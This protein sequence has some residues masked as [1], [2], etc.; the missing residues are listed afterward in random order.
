LTTLR[1]LTDAKDRS[2]EMNDYLE[3]ILVRLTHHLKRPLISVQGALSNVR[4]IRDKL[5]RAELER[6]IRIGILAAK[7]AVIL[8][9][10]VS[11]VL[12]PPPEVDESEMIDVRKELKELA[13]GMALT[14]MREDIQFRYVG[15]SPPIKMNRGSFLYVSYVLIDN[16]IKYA[17]SG[18]DVSFVCADEPGVEDYVF[19]VKSVGLPI[20]RHQM[21]LVFQKYWRHPKAHTRDDTGVGLGCWT[22]REH[23]KRAGGDLLLEVADDLTVFIVVP[24]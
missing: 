11:K 21:E 6:Q 18:T 22:A 5:P 1:D 20:E 16:A 3:D 10:G 24:P 23:M 19:K 9:T 12:A 17:N 13:E 7:H 2:A 14:S 8:C 15:Q 4:D